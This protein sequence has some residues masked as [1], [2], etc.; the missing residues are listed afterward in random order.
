VGGPTC[1][2]D[3]APAP[4]GPAGSQHG[5][6]VKARVGPRRTPVRLTSLEVDPHDLERLR[7][8]IVMI[9]PGHSAGAL[10]REAAFELIE[11]VAHARHETARSR[12]AVT[13]LR[14]LVDSPD[15][16][17][18]RTRSALHVAHKSL[19]G[20][21]L[22]QARM[23]ARLSAVTNA[24]P[25]LT[26]PFGSVLTRHHLHRPNVARSPRLVANTKLTLRRV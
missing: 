5:S 22:A 18:A 16:R 20:H 9:S 23:T 19:C 6:G 1:P 10:T 17:A 4:Q 14:G 24:P 15:G 3:T 21:R 8:S 25:P 7:R 2:P 11:E 26:R 13:Q 12:H